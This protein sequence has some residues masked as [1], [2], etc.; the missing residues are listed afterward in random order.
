MQALNRCT[1]L[2]VKQEGDEVETLGDLPEPVSEE[3]PSELITFDEK[4]V[5]DVTSSDE[6]EQ[7]VEEQ[8]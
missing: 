2:L 6:K 1:T 5:D 7:V 8:Q 3:M 4:V